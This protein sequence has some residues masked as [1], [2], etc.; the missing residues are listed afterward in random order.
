M[1]RIAVFPGSFDPITLGHESIVRRALSLF[2]QVVVAI[3]VNAN[4]KYYFDLEQRKT[5]IEETFADTDRVKVD[6]YQ[7]LT[8]NY[9]QSIGARF[10]LRGLRSGID[11]EYEKAIGQMNH[12]LNHDIETYFLLT[13]PEHAAINSTI[14]RDILRN[15]G[16]ARQFLPASIHS[17]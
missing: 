6:T 11:F 1:D 7:G 17:I 8:I 4:K 9:C 13:L 2:D 3:G 15:G 10:I 12:A 16:E 14:V 5:L